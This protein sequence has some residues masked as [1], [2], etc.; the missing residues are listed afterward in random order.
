MIAT[1][2]QASGLALVAIGVGVVFPPAGLVIAGIGLFVF[3]LAIERGA[4]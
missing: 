2:F 3:G 1:L 4:K